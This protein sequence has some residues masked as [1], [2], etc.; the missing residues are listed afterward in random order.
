MFSLAFLNVA[1]ELSSDPKELAEHAMLVD[2]ARNDLARVARPGTRR[3]L[4]PP[5]LERLSRVQHL[6]S[7]VVAELDEGLDALHAYRAAANMG[8]LTGAPKLRASE[9]LR[10]MEPSPRGFY[11]GAVGYYACADEN[12]LE[13]LNTAIAIRC[14]LHTGDRYHLRAGAGIVADSDPHAELLETEAK[15]ACMRAAVRA[16][17]RG[18]E[19]AA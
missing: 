17:E 1:C 15:L 10:Q 6:V 13:E 4:G 8:T 11:G 16:A 18:E 9:L 2:L 19:V 7:R 14:A 5:H 3:V 12:G